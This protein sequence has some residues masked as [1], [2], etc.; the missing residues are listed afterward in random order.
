M[1]LCMPSYSSVLAGEGAALLFFLLALLFLGLLCVLFFLLV[2]LFA[3]LLAVGGGP[4]LALLPRHS[5]REKQ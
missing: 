1:Q 4:A 5:I 2:L 3:L